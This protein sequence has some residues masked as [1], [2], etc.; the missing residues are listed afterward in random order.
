MCVFES[1]VCSF[2]SALFFNGFFSH[3]Y[4][5][6]RLS[7]LLLL[8]NY[9]LNQYGWRTIDCKYFLDINNLICLKKW[10]LYSC[11]LS[12]IYFNVSSALSNE[13]EIR[14]LLFYVRLN[15]KWCLFQLNRDHKLK[16]A[17]ETQ[18]K[19]NTKFF[20]HKSATLTSSTIINSY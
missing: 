10:T 16:I 18:L 3:F 4:V 19:S 20:A 6:V 5:S 13:G 1:F 15:F 7:F 17:D 11:V 14:Q 2:I 8:G 12:I 9:Q